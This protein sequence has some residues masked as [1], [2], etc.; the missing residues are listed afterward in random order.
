MFI[1]FGVTLLDTPELILHSEYPY[2]ELAFF[3][4]LDLTAVYSVWG[5]DYV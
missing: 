3:C 1:Y 4:M 2:L 5:R